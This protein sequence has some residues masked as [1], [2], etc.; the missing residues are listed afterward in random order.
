MSPFKIVEI[1]KSHRIYQ[2]YSKSIKRAFSKRFGRSKGDWYHIKASNL[3]YANAVAKIQ[4]VKTFEGRG[5]PPVSLLESY[6]NITGIDYGDNVTNFY[7]TNLSPEVEKK[8]LK[9]LGVDYILKIDE[10]R[11]FNNPKESPPPL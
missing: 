9:S 2:Y 7:I 10:R 5:M 1:Y 4:G 3:L 6:K 11:K 8:V